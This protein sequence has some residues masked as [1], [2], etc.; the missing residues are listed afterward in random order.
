MSIEPQMKTMKTIFLCLHL[1]FHPSQLFFIHSF[2]VLYIF[3][4]H[5]G[6]ACHK[7]IFHCFHLW[8]NLTVFLPYQPLVF[9]CI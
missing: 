2:V 7:N 3:N 4:I 9:T 6:Q 8:F 5:A 1:R